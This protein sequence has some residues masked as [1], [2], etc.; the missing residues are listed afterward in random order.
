[1]ASRCC[2]SAIAADVRSSLPQVTGVLP[3]CA[4]VPTAYTNHSNEG[5]MRTSPHRTHLLADQHVRDLSRE[6]HTHA[7]AN[8]FVIVNT[9]RPFRF[10]V[11]RET[12]ETIDRFQSLAVA[13]RARNL[14]NE[15]RA[16]VNPHAPISLKVEEMNGD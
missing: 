8:K 10:A 5:A 1:M 15:K 7:N 12:G 9:D 11:E 16:I 2:A 3:P 4:T 14:L 13:I 6:A